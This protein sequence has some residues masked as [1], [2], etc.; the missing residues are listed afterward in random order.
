ML[1]PADYGLIGMA[2]VVV[3]FVSIFK[4]L[5]LSEATVQRSSITHEQVST[6]FWVNVGLGVVSMLLVAASAPVVAWFYDAPALGPVTL[7]LSLAFPV[8]AL[9][10]QHA[11]LLR[12][13]MRFAAL[14]SSDLASGVVG[15]VVA[16]LLAWQGAQYWALVVGRLAEALS[17][18]LALWVASGW[19]PGLPSG[20]ADV[21]AMLA[22]GGNLTGF[23]LLN[24]LARNIDNLLIGRYWGAEQLGLYSRAYQLL[25]LPIR[26]FNT[27][28]AAVAVPA[29]SRL[30]SQPERYRQ[31]YLR[32]LE[33]I[34]IITMPAVAFAIVTADWL[35]DVALGPRWAE[36]GPLF[37]I[38]GASALIQPVAN[39]VGWL[40]LSQDRTRDLLHWGMIGSTVTVAGI[41]LGLPWGAG[42]VAASYSIT[43]L[44][45]AAPLLFWFVGKKGPVVTQDFYRTA[46]P[47]AFA[48]TMV[49][50]ALGGLRL[51]LGD[52]API[53]GL[54][55]SASCAVVVAAAALLSLPAGRNALRDFQETG[56]LL[57]AGL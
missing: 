29:L 53:H 5:G 27:P 35:V 28:I 12:R 40:F 21:G 10:A 49:L 42:G 6:L 48:A 46:S 43:F 54:L 37:A 34:T 47:A 44:G 11:A 26:Q 33:K 50:I 15:L 18:V 25:L 8:G 23:S 30:A 4:D 57:R 39:T 19:R 36:V 52:I 17:L 51:A 38:L 7:A 9:A 16:A 20:R 55:A 13:Q 56:R 24:Y 2:G 22:F 31:A 14:A 32:V 41:L 45:L 3:G 1:N